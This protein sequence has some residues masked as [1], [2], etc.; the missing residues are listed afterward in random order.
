MGTLLGYVFMWD[1]KTFERVFH[2]GMIDDIVAIVGVD[3]SPDSAGNF[4]ATARDVLTCGI[5]QVHW[6]LLE[7]RLFQPAWTVSPSQ[8]RHSRYK[9][10]GLIKPRQQNQGASFLK[11]HWPWEHFASL[12]VICRS[13]LERPGEGVLC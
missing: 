12:T 7:L 6:N 2:T 10:K 5:S 3:F 4:M 13:P 9:Q 1:A 11:I 8:V